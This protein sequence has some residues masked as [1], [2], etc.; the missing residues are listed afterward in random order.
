[1]TELLKPYTVK[2]YVETLEY[3]TVLANSQREAE[4]LAN[5]RLEGRWDRVV[6]SEGLDELDEWF[7][8]MEEED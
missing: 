4:E 1:M 7:G 5:E 8:A 2:V 6:S 3:R